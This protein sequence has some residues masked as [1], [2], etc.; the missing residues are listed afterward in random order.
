MREKPDVIGLPLEE[1]LRE[2]EAAGYEVNVI[3]TR[4]VK[5]VPGGRARALR[6]KEVSSAG[7]ELTAVYEDKGKGGVDDGV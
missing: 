7:G 2:L 4:P 6:F 5:G 1:A 3:F